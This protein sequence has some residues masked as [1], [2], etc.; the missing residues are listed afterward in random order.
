MRKKTKITAGG[1]DK[2]RLG[3]ILTNNLKKSKIIP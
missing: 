1:F 2:I 3:S